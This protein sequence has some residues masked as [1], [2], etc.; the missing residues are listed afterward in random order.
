MVAPFGEHAFHAASAEQYRDSPFDPGAEPLAL[1]KLPALLEGL[2]LSTA[3]AAGLSDARAA[4]AGRLTGLQ[5]RDTEEAPISTIE[6]GRVAKRVS[7]PFQGRRDVLVIHGI[8]CEHAILRHQPAATLGEEHLVAE[9][10]RLPI[11]AASDQIRM[12][13]EDRIDLLIGR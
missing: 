8:A 10:I 3:L 13:F 5:V 6:C 4:H 1:F 2:P 7:V 9:L 11:L 12:G